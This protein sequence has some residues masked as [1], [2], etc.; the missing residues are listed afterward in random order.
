MPFAAAFLPDFETEINIAVMDVSFISQTKLYQSVTNVIKD[1]SIFISLIKPQFEAAPEQLNRGVVKN[2][3]IRRDIIKKFE[4]W[5][6]ANS[7]TIINKRDNILTG[8]HG[9]QERFYWL[10]ES[11]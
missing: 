10:R 3:K 9:N 7:F 5:L 11:K 1:N 6:K 4:Q 8:K 2:E